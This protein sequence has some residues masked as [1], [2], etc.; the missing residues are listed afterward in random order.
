MSCRIFSGTERSKNIR[1]RTVIG[2]VPGN[3]KKSDFAGPS[4]AYVQISDTTYTVF[5]WLLFSI[6]FL[7]IAN[8]YEHAYA[9]VGEVILLTILA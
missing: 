1:N 6:Q 7:C 3:E 4:T 8:S 9:G 5:R 2:E